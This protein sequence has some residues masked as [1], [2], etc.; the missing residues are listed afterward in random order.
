[1]SM[2]TSERVL[3]KIL[4]GGSFLYRHFLWIIPLLI[5]FFWT[6]EL[7]QEIPPI[8]PKVEP[9]IT[10]IDRF[11]TPLF[12]LYVLLVF[13]L[14]VGSWSMLSQKLAPRDSRWKPYLAGAILLWSMGFANC[15]TGVVNSF[16]GLILPFLLGS[17][18]YAWYAY[19]Q[20]KK[21]YP[22]SLWILL[23]SGLYVGYQFLSILWSVDPE[24][25]AI[26]AHKE[27][28]LF[29]V[30]CAA[31]LFKIEKE[32]F[33]LWMHLSLRILYLF[34]WILCLLYVTGCITYDNSL[35][36][37]FTFNKFF[38]RGPLGYINPQFLLSPLGL[39]H[40]TYL[41]FMAVL[42]L[43]YL[44][45]S[46]QWSRSQSLMIMGISLLGSLDF[47]VFQSRT[48]MCLFGVIALFAFLRS[49]LSKKRL[50]QVMIA[51]G[52]IGGVLVGVFI[53]V[54]PFWGDS[55]RHSLY[56]L[57]WHYIPQHPLIGFGSG[58]STML[59]EQMGNYSTHFHNQWIEAWVSGG[60]IA[61][62]LW[63]GLF[64]SMIR[65]ALHPWHPTALLYILLL[66]GLLMIDLIT[67]LPEYL[68]PL[69]YL[70]LLC[71]SAEPIGSGALSSSKE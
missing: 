71:L 31:L 54:S 8:D 34:F 14:L 51:L 15:L 25:S 22:Q 16:L 24:M 1:M 61:F 5:A 33:D 18:S 26:H 7:A 50:Q 20:K 58:S 53:S 4:Q 17:A 30:P 68:I 49:T 13:S 55:I 36:L 65:K 70:F 47:W 69:W 59:L 29:V 11:R 2:P 38:F 41:G 35:L 39:S 52:V 48:F 64:I 19:H 60:V 56:P 66:G 44:I 23:L 46:P 10:L 43:L 3:S 45:S 28:W 67:W 12:L 57:A 40:Y 32:V 37:G 63:V 42:P 62:M 6:I 27:V 9:T 21:L